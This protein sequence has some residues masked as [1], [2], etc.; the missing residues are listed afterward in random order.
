MEVASPIALQ[1][2]SAASGAQR[3]SPMMDT[4]NKRNAALAAEEERTTKRRRFA[5]MDVDSL[6]ED[7]SSHSIFYKS[8]GGAVAP[9]LSIAGKKKENGIDWID[10]VFIS[11]FN[12]LSFSEFQALFSTVN[13]ISSLAHP[14]VFIF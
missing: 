4:S 7:F 14:T 10:L 12:R 8:N 1:P 3:C 13:T 5:M 2:A 6:S 9:N 11:V